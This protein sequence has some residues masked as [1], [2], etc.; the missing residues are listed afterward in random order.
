MRTVGVEE[1]F[2]VLSRHAPRPQPVGDEVVAAAEEGSDG[3]FEHELMQEQVEL[4]TEPHE[5]VGLLRTEIRA[6]RGELAEAARSHDGR[7]AALATS[8]LPASPHVTPDDRYERMRDTFGLVAAAQLS[9]GMHMHVSVASREE[10]VHVLRGLRPWLPLLL[11]LTTSSPFWDG[12][13]T[14]YA[15]YRTVLWGQ[16]P[17]SGAVP[18][19]RTPA[20]YDALVA[21][22]VASGAARDEGMVYFDARLSRRYPTV[23]VRVCDVSPYAHDA[24]TVA[25]L[26]RALVERL[27]AASPIPETV[28]PEKLW[29]AASWRAARFGMTGEL[30][31]LRDGV[32]LVPAWD[33]VGDLLA[34]LGPALSSLGDR[35]FAEEGLERIRDRGTGA[36]LQRR[37]LEETGSLDAVVDAVSEQTVAG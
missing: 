1:E 3:Q 28:V 16:W 24:A 5:S 13:D 2:L 35:T 25:T 22:L 4:G 9:C 33:L 27:A 11:A 17:T 30:L 7:L 34:Y 20:R 29:T 31:D 8:P 23:E 15:G 32:R 37:V 18:D 19:V 12:R 14:G 6:R 36:D 10:G 26:L 21:D